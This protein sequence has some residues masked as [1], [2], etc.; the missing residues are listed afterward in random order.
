MKNTTTLLLCILLTEF[1]SAQTTTLNGKGLQRT[2]IPYPYQR[3]ADVLW[4]KKVW[5]NIDLREKINA[6]LRY[7]LMNESTEQRSFIA[8]VM[9]AIKDGRLL[10]YRTDDDEF[11]YPLTVSEIKRIGAGDT[12]RI[13]V[14][15]PFCSVP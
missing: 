2:Q 5:R 12:M 13:T 6:P 14:T 7:P 15:E 10:P 9:N 4:S 8:I 3:E 11:T 1:A